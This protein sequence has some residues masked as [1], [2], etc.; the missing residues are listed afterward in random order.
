MTLRQITL[1]SFPEGPS[2]DYLAR[3]STG[4]AEMVRAIPEIL[5]ASWGPDVS[6]NPANF[7]F[8]L[9]LDFADRAALDRYKQHAAHQTFI[10]AYMREIPIS[11]VRTQYLV[12]TPP[13]AARP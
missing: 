1:F 8:A 6:G 4:V 2:A 11:K 12:A 7:G 5:D 13:G 9:S 10:R 3:M